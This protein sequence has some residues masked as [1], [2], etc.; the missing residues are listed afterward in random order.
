MDSIESEGRRPVARL[1]NA[2][3][4]AVFVLAIDCHT[5]PG[6]RHASGASALKTRYTP[7]A[8]DLRHAAVVV[9]LLSWF[10]MLAAYSASAWGGHVPDCIPHLAGCASISASGRH[11]AGFFIFKAA[12]IPAAAFYAV[13]WLLCDHWLRTCAD[14]PARWRRVMLA[15]GLVGAAAFVLYATFL[16]S[17][18][19]SYRAM[20]RYG[21]V[22]FFG[23]TY[24]A[25]LL[26]LYRARALFGDTPLVRAKVILCLAMLAEGLVLG[27]LTYF[28]ANDAWLENLTEWHVAS[29]LAFYPF[30]TWLMWRKTS[31]AVEFKSP[32]P[33][34]D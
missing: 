2:A 31:F 25:Q 1:G 22:V 14:A 19:D 20:R 11:G 21:T 28:V 5:A 32:S 6:Q 9:W 7:A 24:L 23:F 29:A 27:A 4:E 8:V 18:G 13:Y 16:G 17:D 30:L 34:P 12:M 15:V 33:P 3:H 10:G 26:L